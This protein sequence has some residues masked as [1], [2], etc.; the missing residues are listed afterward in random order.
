MI[1]RVDDYDV[2]FL[3][4]GYDLDVAMTQQQMHDALIALMAELDPDTRVAWLM[5]AN[6]PT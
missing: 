5:E 3:S 1:I 6:K 4:H 2:R